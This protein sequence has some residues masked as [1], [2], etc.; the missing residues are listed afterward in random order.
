[1]VVAVFSFVSAVFA[2]W[3]LCVRLSL[4]F[5]RSHGEM[6]RFAQHDIAVAGNPP[7][8]AMRVYEIF[9]S[10]QGETSRAGVPMDFVR[11]AG[12]DLACTY[13]DTTAARDASAGREMT[14][15][16]VVAALPSPPLPW[17][18]VTGGEPLL[19]LAE[20]NAL[21]AALAETGRR[22]LVE[23]CGAHS[24]ADLDPRAVRILDVKTPGS[25]M[26]DRMDWANLDRLRPEDEV[27]FVLTGR[28]DYEWAAA[29]VDRHDLAARTTVLMGPARPALDAAT[30]AKWLLRD[31]RSV[32]L[33]LALHKDLG[34]H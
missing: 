4:R 8:Q 17:V 14:A 23:T 16:E 20:V 18:A 22:V 31:G 24:V 13:C 9:R 32:R 34:L 6:L 19:Q 29:L 3:R 15:G 30:V 33:N 2:A 21:V 10:L 28:A 12:C 11:L 25:G 7:R 5:C 27:K 26:A 1:V